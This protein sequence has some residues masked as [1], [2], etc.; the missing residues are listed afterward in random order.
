MTHIAI[1]IWMNC[2]LLF[3]GF[4]LVLRNPGLEDFMLYLELKVASSYNNIKLKTLGHWFLFSLLLLKWY[5]MMVYFAPYQV[6][7]WPLK[8][9]RHWC[10]IVSRKLG[11]HNN[12]NCKCGTKIHPE[13]HPEVCDHFL[14]MNPSLGIYREIHPPQ[15]IR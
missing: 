6:C 10:S 9:R 7:L 14:I 13:M 4:I 11:R 12:P 5:M 3:E 1:K 8:G 15:K 2:F